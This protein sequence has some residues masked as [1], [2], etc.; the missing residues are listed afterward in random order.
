MS[1][2]TPYILFF[3]SLENLRLA[4]NLLE[5]LTNIEMNSLLLAKDLIKKL[6]VNQCFKNYATEKQKECMDVLI[7]RTNLTKFVFP[8]NRNMQ[9]LYFALKKHSFVIFRNFIGFY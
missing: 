4:A 6:F 7:A 9:V 2:F 3:F 5:I 1:Y 8:P